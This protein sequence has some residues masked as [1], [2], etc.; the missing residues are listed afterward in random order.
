MRQAKRMDTTDKVDAL[1]CAIERNHFTGQD[2]QCAV[3]HTAAA[4]RHVQRSIEQVAD[5]TRD[6]FLAV[7]LKGLARAAC[8][9]VA[10]AE[11]WGDFDNVK[12]ALALAL[13]IG[14]A[15]CALAEIEH[16]E[17]PCHLPK[18]RAFIQTK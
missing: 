1:L 3:L 6:A 7:A 13:H 12:A 17:A 8:R 18:K 9:K 4:L 15:R 5:R 11:R 2:I 10:Q 16:A 14:R